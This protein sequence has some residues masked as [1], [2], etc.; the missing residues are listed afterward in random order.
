MN[1][2]SIRTN[3]PD[4]VSIGI[5]INDSLFSVDFGLKMNGYGLHQGTNRKEEKALQ[6]FIFGLKEE[7]SGDFEILW[8]VLWGWGGSE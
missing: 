6:A 2:W 1:L 5:P 4:P 8:L 7:F 3:Q